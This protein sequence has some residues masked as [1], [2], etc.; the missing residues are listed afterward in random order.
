MKYCAFLLLMTVSAWS[1]KDF[2]FNCIA[3]YDFKASDTSRIQKRW[4]WINSRDNTYRLEIVDAGKGKVR[5][6]FLDINGKASTFYMDK[7]QF[8]SGAACATN[9]DLVSDAPSERLFKADQYA[10]TAS[11]TVVDGKDLIHFVAANTDPGR[12][13]RKKHGRSHFVYGEQDEFELP[14]LISGFDYYLWKADP[15]FKGLPIDRFYITADGRRVGWYHLAEFAP[16]KV[17]FIL[18]KECAE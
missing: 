4:F 6:H 12:E 17:L 16:L 2:V 11:D 7:E 10:L 3:E 13:K 5:C 14:L 15:K 1:Q 18:P 9:C 8:F